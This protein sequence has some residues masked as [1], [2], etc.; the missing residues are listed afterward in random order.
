V[1]IVHVP[2]RTLY[3]KITLFIQIGKSDEEPSNP[4]EV[5]IDLR[6]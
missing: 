4:E 3:I 2:V 5:L 1:S 6:R